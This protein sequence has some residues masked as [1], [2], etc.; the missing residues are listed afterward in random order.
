MKCI[1]C[2][3]EKNEHIDGRWCYKCKGSSGS[4]DWQEFTPQEKA[5]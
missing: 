2:G 3:K 1:N 4:N 5:E